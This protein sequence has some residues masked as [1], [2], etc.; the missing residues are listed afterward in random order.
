MKHDN[1]ELTFKRVS[2]AT[3]LGVL[4]AIVVE[5]SCKFVGVRNGC[6]LLCKVVLKIF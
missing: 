5:V 2:G 4:G 3:F 6:Q 1:E